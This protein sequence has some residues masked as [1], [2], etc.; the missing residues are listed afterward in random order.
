MDSLDNALEKAVWMTRQI[1]K[2]DD[3]SVA[4]K[5]DCL[6]YG[7]KDYEDMLEDLGIRAD[8]WEYVIRKKIDPKLVFAHP[9]ILMEYPRASLYYRGMA[10]LPH[11]HVSNITSTVKNW[12][13]KG[14]ARRPKRDVCKRVA[15][16][17]NIVISTIILDSDDWDPD[18]G[19]RNIVAT[20]GIMNDG[21]WRNRVGRNGEKQVKA[22]IVK[23]LE[24][25]SGIPMEVIED[26]KKY[27]LGHH[28]NV[29]RMRFS[30]EPDVLFERKVNNS[31]AVVSTVE[32]KS[33]MDPAGALER[34]GAV[35]KSFKET[36][37][38]AQNFLILRTT[39]STMRKR[40]ENTSIKTFDMQKIQTD[41][42][43]RKFVNEV[44]HYTLKLT[45]K[46]WRR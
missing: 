30:S 23:W 4:E 40:L 33:G 6:D 8:A 16:L 31:W 15:N 38:K 24:S 42:G 5:I 19:H 32:I 43:K 22:L 46:P 12:E 28:P 25:E 14:Y 29:I 11:K 21:A 17:Y 3:M 26:N 44:F 36:P 35:Q 7:R 41:D 39:T 10:A 45:D 2:R 18:D 9:R 37:A 27:L 34:L 13:Q 1:R 20:I